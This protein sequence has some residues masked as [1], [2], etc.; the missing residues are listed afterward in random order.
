MAC[1]HRG[2][3]LSKGKEPMPTWMSLVTQRATS[4]RIHC[5][6]FQRKHKYKK[7]KQVRACLAWGEEVLSAR[8][9]RV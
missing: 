6:T 7:G 1:P 9:G 4:C 8:K 5:T 3:L 2:I